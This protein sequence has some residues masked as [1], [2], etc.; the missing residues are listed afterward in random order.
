MLWCLQALSAAAQLAVRDQC[1]VTVLVIEEPGTAAKDPAK[2]IESL[3]WHLKNKGCLD[4]AVLQ[5]STTQPA[6]VMVGEYWVGLRGS[7]AVFWWKDVADIPCKA[8]EA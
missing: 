7:T 8:Q 1:K 2:Q 3:N 6:S 4:F 5:R